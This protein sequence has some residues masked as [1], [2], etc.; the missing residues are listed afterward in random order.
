MMKHLIPLITAISVLSTACTEKIRQADADCTSGSA[1]SKLVGDTGSEIEQGCILVKL[2]ES[3][4][5]AVQTGVSDIGEIARGVEITSFSR[6][7]NPAPGKEKT[8]R[9]YGLHQW[10]ELRFDDITPEQ[11]AAMLAESPQVQAVQYNSLTEIIDSPASAEYVPETAVRSAAVSVS[12]PFNDPYLPEQ[13]NLINTGD[14]E[15]SATAMAGA[16]VGVKDAWRLTAGDPRVIVAV[17]DQGIRVTHK[18]LVANMWVNPG[19]I[20]GN[21]IDDDDNDYV[22]DIYG[23]NFAEDKD[24]PSAK[25]GQDH[26]THIAGTIAATN[27]NSLGV[28][29]I[30]GGSGNGDGVRLMSCQI[31]DSKGYQTSDSKVAAAFIYAAHNGASIAQCSYGEEGGSILKDEDYEKNAPLE[32]A[33]MRY[34][35]DPAN[36]NCE[37]LESNIIVVSAGNHNGPASSY[38]AALPFCISV[39]AFGP[40]FMPASYTNYGPGCD[41]SAPGGDIVQGRNDAPCMILSTGIGNMGSETYVYKYGTSMAAPHVT[42]VAALGLSYALKI[43]KRFTREDFVSRLLTS[44]NDLDGRIT[45]PY[46]KTYYNGETKAYEE[47]DISGKR[48]KTGTGGVDAWNFLMALEGTPSFMTAPGEKLTIDVA[49]CLGENPDRF[50]Y[51]LEEID[52]ATLEALG[53]EEQPVVSNG[54]MEIIC[55]STGSGKLR[56]RAEVGKGDEGGISGQIFYR[57]ISIVSRPSLAKN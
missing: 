34:F 2:T 23:Y 53:I 29:S 43:G 5:S 41:I 15:I 37:A 7:M 57:E 52:P 48:Y 3:A 50:E 46:S 32:V 16:D 30:A 49:E 9:K 26:G 12:M 10:Y 19:E 27:N 25:E 40:D 4:A 28:S 56:F 22:D 51:T 24:T 54:K 6:L 38:P 35:T 8:A 44:A 36:S 45:G 1:I 11:A 14:T 33:A 42:G 13:W 31:F 18:D 21:D 17:M 20:P 39:T 47:I 55:T